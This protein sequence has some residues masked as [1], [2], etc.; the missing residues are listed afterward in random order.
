MTVTHVRVHIFPHGGVNRLRLFGTAVDTNAE[1]AARE[2]LNAL[3]AAEAKAV[4]ASFN[5]STQWQEAML[6]RRPFASVRAL[7]AGA[8][9]AWWSRSEADWLEAFA[10]HPRIGQQKKAE[11]QNEKS[12]SWSKGE[13]KGVAGA[14]A[15]VLDR[16][17]AL[18]E[19]YFEKFGFIYIVCATGKSARELLA[20]L[21]E[22]LGRSKA[23]EIEAAAREQAKITRLR[24]AKWLREQ[25][26]T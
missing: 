17:G 13:Q 19:Q 24:I 2:K 23:Q 7:Y 5:G 6:A 12:A 18:N 20:L 4:F 10:A 26:S 22:R 9:E 8:D 16:L 3:D 14:D 21:E 11:T 15:E 1:Q 25:A